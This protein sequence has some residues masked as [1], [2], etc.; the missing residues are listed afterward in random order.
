[1]III[2]ATCDFLTKSVC[3]NAVPCI[4]DCSYYTC[5]MVTYTSFYDLCYIVIAHKLHN[6]RNTFP[7]YHFQHLTHFTCPILYQQLQFINDPNRIYMFLSRDLLFI[8]NVTTLDY[9]YSNLWSLFDHWTFNRVSIYSSLLRFCVHV[10]CDLIC[11]DSLLQNHIIIYTIVTWHFW[12]V[13]L[14]VFQARYSVQHYIY[15]T[16]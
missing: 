3:R 8:L 5:L 4:I 16:M 14:T 10:L 13:A 12:K 11:H 9:Y 2:A 6:L 15:K 1:M 7:K